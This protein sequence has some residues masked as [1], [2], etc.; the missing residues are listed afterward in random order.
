METSLH[1]SK[2]IFAEV[3]DE[4]L[5]L[6][7]KRAMIIPIKSFG[8]LQ[9][10][11]ITNIGIDR[12]K[13][14]FFQYGWNLGKEDAKSFG[15]DL[16]ISLSDKGLY[17][18]HFHAAGH[19]KV[20]VTGSDITLDNGKVNSIVLNGIW[21]QSY[22]ASQHIENFG[23]AEEPICYTLTGYASG[24]TSALVGQD[25]FFKEHQ[26]EGEGARLLCMGR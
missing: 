5:Y 17:G 12:M 13:R 26:C 19:T 11:L 15:M 25:V 3:K 8:I 22:E 16:P 23:L 20:R 21:E 14:F 7:K 4:L 18:P 9:R 10:D 24:Y 6:S 1:L 2:L